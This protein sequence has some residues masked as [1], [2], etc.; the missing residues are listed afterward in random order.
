MIIKTWR[1]P[2]DAGFSPTSPKEI[3]LNKGLTVLVGCNGA[4]KSTLIANIEEYCKSI[5]IPVCKYD[6]LSSGGSASYGEFLFNGDYAG[7]SSMWCSSEGEA[8]K[9]NVGN[10][11]S[12]LKHFFEEG[13]ID[14]RHN[15][16]VRCF[17]DKD[18]L[19]EEKETVEAIKDRVIL[20]DAVD[21][22]LSVDSVIEIKS[23][24]NL[25]FEDAEK[26]GVNLYIIIAANEYELARGENCF[27]VNKGKYLQFKDY[28]DYRN[29]IIK[30]RQNKEKRIQKQIKW[31]E[32]KKAKEI[33]EYKNKKIKYLEKK[34]AFLSTVKDRDNLE[35]REKWKLGDIEDEWKYFV[36]SLEYLSEKDIKEL[37]NE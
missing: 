27:D 32:N 33:K 8:I 34:E 22:G 19:D 23:L 26:M 3:T 1:D 18:K 24:F 25:I 14:N 30:S 21:S 31:Y 10:L 11:S 7:L 36:R 17:A 28:E 20:F 13:W 12:K 37:E 29:F 4:G 16:F 9:N 35:M 2:Y 5:K 6:N 15:R